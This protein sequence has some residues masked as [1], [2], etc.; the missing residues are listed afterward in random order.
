MKTSDLS[1]AHGIDEFE[2]FQSVNISKLYCY[3][4]MKKFQFNW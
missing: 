3:V 1:G 4:I 2:V